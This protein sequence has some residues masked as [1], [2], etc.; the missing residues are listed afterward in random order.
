[1]SISSI[2]SS[3]LSSLQANQAMQA[4]RGAGDSDGDNDGSKVGE[5]ESGSAQQPK[6]SPGSM[7]G[8]RINTV[9]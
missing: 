4:S 1:M 5:V 3:I 7:S 2:G 8:S 9:A 6:V